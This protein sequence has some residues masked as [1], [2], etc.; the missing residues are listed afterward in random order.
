MLGAADFDAAREFIEKLGA[1]RG[2]CR[3][4]TMSALLKPAVGVK[5]G[6]QL[7][8]V[9][10]QDRGAHGDGAADFFL[11]LR[12]LKDHLRFGRIHGAA[13]SLIEFGNLLAQFREHL[14]QR[15]FAAIK[16]PGERFGQKRALHLFAKP[17]R[18]AKQV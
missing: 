10:V 5:L 17:G 3:Q 1:L 8:L 7:A 18:A 16:T 13:Q 4:K 6:D 15:F 12:E 2:Q 11:Q 14:L 9:R